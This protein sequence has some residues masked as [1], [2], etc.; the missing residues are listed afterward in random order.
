M[1][2]VDKFTTSHEYGQIMDNPIYALARTS[3]RK[4]LFVSDFKG[5]LKQLDISTGQVVN[6]YGRIHDKIGSIIVSS[7]NLFLFTSEFS[8]AGAIK[9]WSISGAKMVKQWAKI[10][11]EGISII[12]ISHDNRFIYA[13]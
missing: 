6:D 11:E 5:Y 7:D 2:A 4:K 12:A 8:G 13:G 10:H 1:F 9:K 3:D